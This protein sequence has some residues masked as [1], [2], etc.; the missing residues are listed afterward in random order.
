MLCCRWLLQGKYNFESA[1]SAV[2]QARRG[3]CVML[4]ESAGAIHTTQLMD[5]TQA[6]IISPVADASMLGHDFVKSAVSGDSAEGF[7][8]EPSGGPCSMPLNMSSSARSPASA[9]D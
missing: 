2:A 1:S 9:H 5:T 6:R 4:A 7:S 3:S 8:R